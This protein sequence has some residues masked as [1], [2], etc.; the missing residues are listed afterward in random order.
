MTMSGVRFLLG[1]VLALGVPAFGVP[2]TYTYQGVGSGTLGTQSFTSAQFTF[3]AQA[4]TN[5]IAPWVNAGGGPQNT[6]L[7]ATILITGLGVFGVTTPS[8]TWLAQGC[9]GGLGADLSANWV[10]ID[11]PALIGVGYGLDTNFGPVVDNSPSHVNQFTNVGTG[12]GTLRF[13]SISTVTFTA[14]TNA[15]PEPST[16]AMLGIS[17]GALVVIRLRKKR[18]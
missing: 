13:S 8:H 18:V 11:E 1:A 4:D 9:C 5:N 12:G 10:T 15:V 3:T 14:S 16:F 2:I 17:G 7:S 6:H